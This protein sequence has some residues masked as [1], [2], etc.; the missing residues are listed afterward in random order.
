MARSYRFFRLTEFDSPDAKGSGERMQDSTMRML[1]NARA[2]AG[3]PFVI[4]SG[5]RTEA[6]NKSVGG[7]S[8]S[9]HLRGFAADIRCL[10]RQQFKVIVIACILAG[11]RRIGVHHT[12]IHVDNDPSLPTA[13]WLYNKTNQE[14]RERLAFVKGAL[15]MNRALQKE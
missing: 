7:S 6:H 15:A 4:N 9:A 14:Q 8:N 3:I 1:D 12:Y 11:F 5:Y 2:L 13:Q 10:E